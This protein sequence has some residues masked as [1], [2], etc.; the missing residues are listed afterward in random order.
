MDTLTVE[1]P[2]DA[3]ASRPFLC[4]P[5]I[6]KI[7]AALSAAQA[8]IGNP[9]K[10]RTAKVKSD[11]GNYE[12]SYA[13]LAAV[14]EAVRPVLS[15]HQI[16]IVQPP[17][18]PAQKRLEVLTVLLHASGEWI[19]S[20]LAIDLSGTR[21]QDVGVAITYLRRYQVQSL[22]GVASED[23]DDAASFPE[24]NGRHFHDDRDDRRDERRESPKAAAQAEAPAPAAAAEPSIPVDGI[25][26]I[27]RVIHVEMDAK[28][29]PVTFGVLTYELGDWVLETKDV[30]VARA[31]V[32]LKKAHPEDQSK[33][34]M[35]IDWKTVNG[36]RVIEQIGPVSS[37]E[38]A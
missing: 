18:M 15:K 35:V 25:Y 29:N 8:E 36:K 30:E 24:R 11:K 38:A 13:D 17:T 16:A 33:R 3:V 23:D 4:S 22:A 20:S 2:D 21:P 32:N 12:Y 6:E 5:T 10:N 28:G 34:R 37:V 7:A 9:T 1:P 19:G 14:L 27:A 31:V 26:T